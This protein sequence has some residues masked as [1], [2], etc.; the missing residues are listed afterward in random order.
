MK[1]CEEEK[2][3]IRRRIKT[4]PIDRPGLMYVEAGTWLRGVFSMKHYC[5]KHI[6]YAGT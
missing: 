3:E 2:N 4:D 5:R 1:S 6:V